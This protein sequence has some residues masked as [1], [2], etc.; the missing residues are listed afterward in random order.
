MAILSTFIPV[1]PKASLAITTAKIVPRAICHKGMVGGRIR[2]INIPVTR[3]PSLI[4]C[5]LIMAKTASTS[6]PAV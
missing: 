2:G 6:P 1:P 5:F 4:G 3:K